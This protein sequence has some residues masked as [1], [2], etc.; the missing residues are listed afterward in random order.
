MN[1][2]K[3]SLTQLASRGWLW[4]NIPAIIIIVIVW[5]FLLTYLMINSR[6]SIL[7][8]VV[9]GWIYWRF[10]IKKWIQWALDNNVDP[11]KI[12]RVGKLSLLLWSSLI[13]DKVIEENKSPN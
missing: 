10:T 11:K 1:E 2:Q 4:V 12:L 8:V 5:Y 13:I 7:I 9:V 6:L 3:L